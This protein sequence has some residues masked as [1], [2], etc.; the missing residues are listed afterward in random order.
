[1]GFISEA[2]GVVEKVQGVDSKRKQQD[3]AGSERIY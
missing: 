3:R 2:A 1:M